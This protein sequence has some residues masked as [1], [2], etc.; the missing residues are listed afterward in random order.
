MERE[1]S[2]SGG[3]RGEEPNQ[4]SKRETVSVGKKKKAGGW[5]STFNGI[6]PAEPCACGATWGAHEPTKPHRIPD[7]CAGFREVHLD[8]WTRERIETTLLS[9]HRLLYRRYRGK[10]LWTFIADITLHG[11]TYSG[12]I[13]RDFGWDPNQDGAIRLERASRNQAPDPSAPRL[14]AEQNSAT[15][16]QI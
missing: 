14:T 7:K 9:V 4:D 6:A 10:P 2:P 12:Q 16:P 8:L 1:E 13:C 15:Q 11:S 3:S 5:Q